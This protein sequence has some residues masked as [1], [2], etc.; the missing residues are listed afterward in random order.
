M[1][2]ILPARVSKEIKKIVNMEADQQRYS[3]MSRTESGAFMDGLVKRE[4]VGGVI[5]QYVP[6]AEVRTYIKDGILNAYSKAYA[7]KSRPSD[8]ASVICAVYNV[9]STF[10]E[11]RGDVEIYAASFDGTRKYFLI[12]YG[13][14]IKWETALRKLLL[15]LASFNDS[16]SSDDV[17]LLAILIAQ[18]KMIAP[19]D[20]ALVAKALARCSA[21]AH[22]VGECG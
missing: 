19:S 21:Q 14:F 10:I 18:G 16:V 22:I 9:E 5:A 8:L 11:K 17:H 12:A 1:A 7:R 20:K 3:S 4:D 15:C 2:N 13:T 6:Q